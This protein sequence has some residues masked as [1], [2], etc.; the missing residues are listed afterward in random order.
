MA[1]PF[2]ILTFKWYTRLSFSPHPCQD[3]FSFVFLMTAILTGVKWH[4][5]V[6]LIYISLTI[7]DAE[8][9]FIHLAIC[10]SS[11]EKCLFGS[12]SHFLI[13]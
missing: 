13:G 1:V 9:L 4:L 7:S 3:F 12:F 10:V 2:Y 11:F 8:H 5:T 6:A